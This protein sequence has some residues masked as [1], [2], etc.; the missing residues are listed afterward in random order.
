MSPLILDQYTHQSPLKKHLGNTLTG[1]GWAFWAYLWLPLLGAITLLL[2]S[3]SPQQNNI[4]LQSILAMTRTLQNHLSIVVTMIALFLA[5]SVLQWI[6]KH[7]RLQALNQQ[8]ITH[9]RSF[10]TH[11]PQELALWQKTK[12]M[13]ISHDKNGAIQLVKITPVRC[14]Q[15]FHQIS[16]VNESAVSYYLAHIKQ[17]A[18]KIS[19]LEIF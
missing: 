9:I 14:Q 17:Q 3:N 15:I 13:T 19:H 18:L 7:Q 4:A 6:G 11:K 8:K 1:L 10:A 16:N 12:S 5:W 2:G